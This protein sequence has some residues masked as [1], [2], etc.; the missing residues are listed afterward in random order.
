[1]NKNLFSGCG[2]SLVAKLLPNMR[3]ALG[4]IPSTTKIITSLRLELN[5]ELGGGGARL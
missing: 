3:D 4:S 5:S 1:M 2:Y